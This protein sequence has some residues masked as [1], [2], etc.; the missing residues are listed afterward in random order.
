LNNTFARYTE[1]YPQA[2]ATALD[3]LTTM[4]DFESLSLAA[5]NSVRSISW[6]DAGDAV[7]G[8]LRDA[9]LADISTNNPA[10][11]EVCIDR[12]TLGEEALPVLS[13]M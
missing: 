3:T 8:L 1:A 7:D 12:G 10:Q 4:E 2:L 6:E 5:S 11:M 9:L 13:S